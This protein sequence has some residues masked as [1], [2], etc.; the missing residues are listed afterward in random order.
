MSC[1]LDLHQRIALAGEGMG[2][3]H[4]GDTFSRKGTSVVHVHDETWT[5]HDVLPKLNNSP[6]F[7]DT[8]AT[9]LS[10]PLNTHLHYHLD[11]NYGCKNSRVTES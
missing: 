7:D 4:A 5:L 1:T 9:Y 8:Q 6:Q 10:V 11:P 2:R 3:L